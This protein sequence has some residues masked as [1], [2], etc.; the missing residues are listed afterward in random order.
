MGF[1]LEGYGIH[2]TTESQSIGKQV[3]AGCI[4]MYNGDV[5]EL[6]DIMPV[7]AEV[8]IID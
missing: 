8:I 1:D 5:Q 6:Y 7:G 2:G 4:R 3:T